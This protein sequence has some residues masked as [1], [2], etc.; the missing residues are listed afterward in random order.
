DATAERESHGD[1][2]PDADGDAHE[3]TDADADANPDRDTNANTDAHTAR[4]A[5][6][7]GRRAATRNRGGAGRPALP[8]R[9]FMCRAGRPGPPR[10]RSTGETA[11]VCCSQ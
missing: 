6:G 9:E 5:P 8:T 3:D 1:A 2:H 11:V 4:L 7:G 10:A